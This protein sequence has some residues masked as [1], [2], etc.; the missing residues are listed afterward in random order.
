MDFIELIRE[1]LTLALPGIDAQMR[2]APPIRKRDMIAPDDARVSGVLILLVESDKAWNTILIRRTED[3]RIHGGQISFPG[4]KKDPSDMDIIATALREAEEEIGVQRHEV[5]VL[6]ILSPLYIP[7]SNFVVTPVV[8]YI[9]FVQAFKPSEREVQEIIKVPLELLLQPSIKEKRNVKRSD[10][11]EE[12]MSTPVYVLSE[13]IVIWG[14]TAMIISELEEIMKL[15]D[16][17]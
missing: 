6:G 13:E 4:G 7:P 12:E 14:A 9:P 1:R 2:M 5:E 17:I 8:G 10:K 11:K 16:L 3:G 15:K